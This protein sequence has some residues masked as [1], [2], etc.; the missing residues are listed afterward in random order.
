VVHDTNTHDFLLQ[1]GYNRVYCDLKIVYR[2]A[3]R[4]CVN[5]LYPYRSLLDHAP[6]FRLKPNI[7]GIL[8]QEEIR[9]SIEAGGKRAVHP[10]ILERIARSV[11]GNRYGTTE[12]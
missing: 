9:R 4:T 12:K 3:V 6:E 10:G 11:G 1:L 2:P 7:R 8:N 5:L